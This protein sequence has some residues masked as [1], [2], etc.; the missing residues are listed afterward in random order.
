M[1]LYSLILIGY[2]GLEGANHIG[3]P[4]KLGTKKEGET[5]QNKHDT[6]FSEIR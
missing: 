6:H 4:F 2:F 1:N 5:F 3:I